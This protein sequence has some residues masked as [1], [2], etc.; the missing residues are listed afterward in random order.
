MNS[1]MNL[2]TA[3]RNVDQTNLLTN[4]D[5][6]INAQIIPGFK[7]MENVD[8]INALILKCLQEKEPAGNAQHTQE[9]KIWEKDVDLIS[10]RWMKSCL[11]TGHVRNAKSMDLLLVMMIN[12]V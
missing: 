12:H 3:Y 9:V 10:A 6:A 4:K 8:L 1:L 2:E 11:K 7:Q 5:T